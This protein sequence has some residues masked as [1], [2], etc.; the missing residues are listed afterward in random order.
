MTRAMQ[1]WN[2]PLWE[3][4]SSLLL[5]GSGEL[6]SFRGEDVTLQTEDHVFWTPANSEK[7]CFPNMCIVC[8]WGIWNLFLRSL[9]HFYW[10]NLCTL[11]LLKQ[12]LKSLPMKHKFCMASCSVLFGHRKAHE[13]C[14]GHLE[15]RGKGPGFIISHSCVL[16]GHSKFVLQ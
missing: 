10:N 7:A 16:Q 4:L 9:N 14:W 15:T 6:L 12:S 11:M 1:K 13:S 5:E 3:T 8:T 2:E